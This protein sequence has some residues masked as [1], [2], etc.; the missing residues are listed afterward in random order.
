M[1]SSSISSASI[2]R[3]VLPTTPQANERHPGLA[4]APGGGVGG[5]VGA[6]SAELDRGAEVG[7]QGGVGLVEFGQCV[8]DPGADGFAGPFRLVAEA[9]GASAQAGCRAEF[10]DQGVALGGQLLGSNSVAV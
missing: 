3:V 4:Q 9:S 1:A 5:G 8:A 6:G 10:V 7:G 2:R